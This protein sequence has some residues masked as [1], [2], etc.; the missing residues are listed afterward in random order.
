MRKSR[1]DKE[2]REVREEL[3]KRKRAR[4]LH[5]EEL[6]KE[7]KEV[8]RRLKARGSKGKPEPPTSV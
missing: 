4:D 5:R 7:A 3:A 2:A 6:G 1:P 8:L